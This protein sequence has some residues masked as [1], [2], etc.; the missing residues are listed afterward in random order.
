MSDHTHNSSVHGSL[1]D[2][3]SEHLKD[4]FQNTKK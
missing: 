1:R 2:Q 4:E 3:E